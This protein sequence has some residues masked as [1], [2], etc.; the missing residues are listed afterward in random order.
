MDDLVTWLGEQLDEDERLASAC[1]PWPWHPNAEGDEVVAA[2]EIEVTTGYALS[3][4]QQRVV[5]SHIARWDPARVLVEVEAKRY[6]LH[7]HWPTKSFA[8]QQ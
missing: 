5:V 7:D 8:G 6:L 1:P 3:S 2:D 4:N